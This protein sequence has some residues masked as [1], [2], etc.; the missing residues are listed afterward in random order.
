M[1]ASDSHDLEQED[2]P[3][4]GGVLQK[5][6][7]SLPAGGRRI[8]VRRAKFQFAAMIDTAGDELPDETVRSIGRASHGQWLREVADSKVVVSD[9]P[10]EPAAGSD[11]GSRWALGL[12]GC[13]IWVSAASPTASS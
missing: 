9:A 8:S 11:R 1:L 5:V 2:Y 4:R 7:E 10:S 12:L 13:H 6:Q 3:W